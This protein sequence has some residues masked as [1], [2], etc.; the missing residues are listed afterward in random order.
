MTGPCLEALTMIH[1]KKFEPWL[2]R[3]SM[4]LADTMT[5]QGN[6]EQINLGVRSAGY[7]D[8]AMASMPSSAFGPRCRPGSKSPPQPGNDPTNI[9]AKPS[10]RSALP[11][12]A[13]GPSL[14][15]ALLERRHLN[16]FANQVSA[17]MTA[18]GILSLYLTEMYLYG[19]NALKLDK[20]TLRSFSRASTGSTKT[21]RSIILT[22]I[23][24]STTTPG[25]SRTSARPPA[26]EHSTRPTGSAKSPHVF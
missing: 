8:N 3:D 22:A 23:P 25:P 11:T 15:P 2:K 19:P 20:P 12:P 7:G 17:S 21:S 1:T 18:G 9:G 6:W 26:I 13:D 5:E 4:W 16:A 14:H 10:A 24:I